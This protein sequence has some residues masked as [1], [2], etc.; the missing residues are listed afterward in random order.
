MKA[1]VPSRLPGAAS[2]GGNVLQGKEPP[3]NRL[4]LE[5]LWAAVAPEAPPTNLGARVEHF[6]LP[7]ATGLA[8]ELIAAHLGIPVVR[9]RGGAA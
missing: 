3:T 9:V 1:H 7:Q 6:Y 4:S 8:S 5:V 2:D